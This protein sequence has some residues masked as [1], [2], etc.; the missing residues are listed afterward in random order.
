VKNI[1]TYGENCLERTLG[2]KETR[3]CRTAHTS[4]GDTNIRYPY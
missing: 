1:Y 2:I 4:Q 3:F